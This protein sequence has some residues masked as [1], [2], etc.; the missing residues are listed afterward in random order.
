MR[1][2]PFSSALREGFFILLLAFIISGCEY[3]NG[4]ENGP[5]RITTGKDTYMMDGNETVTFRSTNH[6][7]VPLFQYS[8]PDA[9]LEKR[10]KGRWKELASWYAVVA[11]VPSPKAVPPGE[12]IH[13]PDIPAGEL[14]FLDFEPGI[15]RV[16]TFVYRTPRM[17]RLIPLEH[18][19]SNAFE[20]VRPSE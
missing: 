20:M 7:G 16:K 3:V 2:L 8:P 6:S 12:S 13:I 9:I 18:R 4:T 17:E 10:E 5:I 11:I 19:V 15:Y 1:P 14:R